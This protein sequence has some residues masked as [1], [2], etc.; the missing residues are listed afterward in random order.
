MEDKHVANIV[1]MGLLVAQSPC[2]AKKLKNLFDVAEKVTVSQI[3]QTLH[4]LASQS[5]DKAWE[6]I[7]TASGWHARTKQEH[8]Q[9]VQRFLVTSP[10]RLSRP[11]MEVLAIVAYNQPAT[12]GEIEAIRGVSTSANQLSSLEELGWVEVS[13]HKE[14]PGRPLLYITSAKLLDDLGLKNIKELPSLE[15][16]EIENLSLAGNNN[17]SEKIKPTIP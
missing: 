11:L 4:S 3:E 8:M 6:I 15:G 7:R 10:P 2:T 12:R 1:E 17:A 13:G 14:T 16:F 9:R 5:S